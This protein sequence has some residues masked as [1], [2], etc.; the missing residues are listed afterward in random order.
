MPQTRAE[1]LLWDNNTRECLPC[2]QSRDYHENVGSQKG[3]EEPVDSD[4]QDRRKMGLWGCLGEYKGRGGEKGT[5][6][7]SGTFRELCD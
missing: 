4:R 2:Y 7:C 6:G 5:V 1:G 3:Q